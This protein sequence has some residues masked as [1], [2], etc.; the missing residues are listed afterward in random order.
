MCFLSVI[1]FCG[2]CFFQINVITRYEYILDCL[3]KNIVL[4]ICVGFIGTSCYACDS[5][6]TN[7]AQNGR[8]VIAYVPIFPQGVP[9]SV[10]CNALQAVPVGTVLPMP[11][12]GP[13]G[14]PPCPGMC[15]PALPNMPVGG[16]VLPHA[17]PQSDQQQP[18]AM[19]PAIPT[20]FPPFAGM[21]HPTLPNMPVGGAMIP[22]PTSLQSDQQQPIM[23]PP[24]GPIGIPPFPGMCHPALPN[25][26]FGGVVMIPAPAYPQ[27]DQQQP[28]VIPTA[29]P[30]D[31]CSGIKCG[32]DFHHTYDAMS[33][34][35][36]SITPAVTNLDY[37][38]GEV[39]V[40]SQGVLCPVN[41]DNTD[42]VVTF[43]DVLQSTFVDMC[44]VVSVGSECHHV[45]HDIHDDAMSQAPSA[46]TQL[47]TNVSYAE[48]HDVSHASG[49]MSATSQSVSCTVRDESA[50]GRVSAVSVVRA[51]T[52]ACRIYPIV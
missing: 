7:M 50:S 36:S 30:P 29:V 17:Y 14:I 25:I 28:V 39:Q 49:E 38:S 16:V 42:P 6:Q 1:A 22:V 9:S 27:S 12:M 33:Q 4:L 35:P 41:S 18:V 13:T 48:K 37:T 20:G 52:P 23:M 8:W 3:M 5:A 40:P 26:P 31:S 11:P 45:L 51:S 24:M 15:H 21:Y 19:P 2:L 46:I 43:E 44:S 34:A 10:N 32:E 47:S